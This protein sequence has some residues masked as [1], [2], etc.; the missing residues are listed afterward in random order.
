MIFKKRFSNPDIT[1]IYIEDDTI[2]LKIRLSDENHLDKRNDFRSNDNQ[3]LK[4]KIFDERE[5]KLMQCLKI[6]GPFGLS[7]VE[8]FDYS[9]RP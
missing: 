6:L 3:K 4:Y 8:P 1:N 2:R 9:F 5:H 7:P